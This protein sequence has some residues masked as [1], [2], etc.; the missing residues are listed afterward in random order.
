VM[1]DNSEVEVEL[2]ADLSILRVDR[3]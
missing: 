3:N 2:A 1:D